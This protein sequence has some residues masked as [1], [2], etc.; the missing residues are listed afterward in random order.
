MRKKPS[1][2]RVSFARRLLQGVLVAGSLGCFAAA[3][4]SS[5]AGYHLVRVV[6]LPSVT[7]WDYLHIDTAKRDLYISNNSG[8]I[9]LNVDTLK[10]VGTVP[11]PAKPAGVGLDHGVATA[12]RL[13]YGFVSWELPA[14]IVTFRLGSLKIV[15]DTRAAPGPD[16]I[17]Y[18]PQ[19]RRVFSFDGKTPGVHHVTVMDARSGRRLAELRLP[20]RPEFAVSDAR[21]DVFV[22][23]ASLSK[24]ERIN[25]STLKMTAL[26]GMRPCR[27]PSALAIDR[28]HDRLFAACGNRI[29]IMMS[30]RSGRVI[31][32]V[33]TT[34]GTDAVRV[35]PATEDVFAASGSGTLTV[36][37]EVT[38][39]RLVPLQQVKTA[40]QARTMALDRRTHRVF[41]VTA[42]F[43]PAPG[44][45]TQE[46]PHGYPLAL[47][48]TAKLL[49]YAP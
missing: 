15:H 34:G 17:L 4:A 19:T 40:P 36:A 41:L 28:V 43:G 46:N 2:R 26:W 3:S 6:P 31:A 30:S 32:S 10:E 20:G 7:G 13:G 5:A 33:H 23:I 48:G 39:Y 35:D 25:A 14:S 27:D 42:R 38:P 44:H 24:L 16:A 8:V 29:M 21:G 45:A 9:V 18:D 37:R 47:R 11:P 49:V 22:N 1:G 12:D